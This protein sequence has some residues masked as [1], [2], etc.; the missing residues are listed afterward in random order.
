MIEGLKSGLPT[1][2]LRS[3]C[4]VKAQACFIQQPPSMCSSMILAKA[5]AKI[6]SA[7]GLI[8]TLQARSSGLAQ[9]MDLLSL[10]VNIKTSA[11]LDPAWFVL[12]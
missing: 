1:V 4:E 10:A 8:E 6:T 5:A 2:S 9:Q 7:T 12:F 11:D 3:S